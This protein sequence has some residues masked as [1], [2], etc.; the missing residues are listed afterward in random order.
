MLEGAAGAL[1]RG[2]AVLVDAAGAVL[3]AAGVWSLH[4]GA[5]LMAAG[6]GCWVLNLVHGGG[7]QASG[8]RR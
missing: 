1:A 7:E 2:R 4:P 8:D 3:V 6:V 5:G